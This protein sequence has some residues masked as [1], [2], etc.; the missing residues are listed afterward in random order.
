M[1]IIGE[2]IEEFVSKQID[3]RQKIY[4][5]INRTT[6]QL[7]Y[8][9]SRNAFIK[10]MSSVNIVDPEAF[11]RD[12]LTSDIYNVVSQYPGSQLAK[13]FMLF[14]GVTDVI[15]NIPKAGLAK[16]NSILND[17]SYGLGGLTFGY[18]PMPGITSIDIKSENRGSLKTAI[19]KIKA[20]NRTQFEIVDLLYLR[21]GFTVLLEWGNTIYFDN[22]GDFKSKNSPFSLQDVFFNTGAAPVRNLDYNEVL[23]QIRTLRRSSSGNYDALYGK[24]VNYEWN[25]A[26]DGSYDITLTVRSIGDVI[27]S[28][29]VN[30]LT[31]TKTNSS[32][33]ADEDKSY[34][35]SIQSYA[36]QHEI[37]RLFNQVLYL[38]AS[39]TDSNNVSISPQKDLSSQYNYEWLKNEYLKLFDYIFFNSHNLVP[40]ILLKF[41]GDSNRS[42][43]HFGT[44]LKFIEN[45]ILPKYYNNNSIPIIKFDAEPETNLVYYNSLQVSADPRICVINTKIPITSGN[46]YHYAMAASPYK[47]T[48][49]GVGKVMNIYFDFLYILTTMDANTDEEGNLSLIDF[50]KALCNDASKTLGGLNAFEPH[51]NEETNEIR[52]IDQTPLPNKNCVLTTLNRTKQN[53]AIIDLYGYY[54]RVNKGST[55]S[56]V[57]NFGIKTELNSSFSTII[58][59]GAQAQGQVVGE[60]AT[61]L[62]RM[63]RGLEDRIV[64]IKIDALESISPKNTQDP[65]PT[66]QEKFAEAWKNLNQFILSLG[67]EIGKDG[68][69]YNTYGGYEAPT[70]NETDANSYGTLF[71]NYLKYKEAIEAIKNNTSSGNIGFIPISLNLTLDGLSG[72]K[73]YNALKVDTSY[74]P[75]NYPETMDFIITGVSHKIQ[76]NLWVTDLTTVMVPKNIKD[77]SQEKAEYDAVEGPQNYVEVTSGNKTSSSARDA[78]RI[79]GID[80]A[81][82]INPN[83]I[84]FQS[85]S[86]STTAKSLASKYSNGELP[87]NILTTI[88]P[89]ANKRWYP[90]GQYRLAPAAAAAWFKWKAAMD[91]RKIPYSVSS[92]YRSKQHQASLGSGKGVAS[93]GSSPHGWGGALDFSNLYSL[94]GGSTNPTVNLNARIRNSVYEQMA[95]LGKQF[96]WYNPWRLSDQ[97][98]VDEIWHFEYWG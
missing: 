84:G 97:S 24:V 92:A 86:Y 66:P 58:T 60:D 15:T 51:I 46:S 20:W 18:R 90:D 5:S 43:I 16:D 27:E 74:L 40:F 32:G 21:L 89:G 9:N 17:A 96:G 77:N 57:R 35:K 14:N 52:I 37:G 23:S 31:T 94:V 61:A 19:I 88:G 55:A 39:L 78:T 95:E 75:S 69:A 41:K 1:N 28:L 6:E 85:Y 48:K 45:Y 98:G 34:D 63:N 3:V 76:N 71:R 53:T 22:E 13:K 70:L 10:L 7:Q 44:L 33:S 2:E 72:I 50:L 4:G 91:T 67:V 11:K 82:A 59:I 87:L 81:P 36:D 38:R 30:I 73:I 64:P 29:K 54:N 47:E 62:S 93:P 79:A 26:E 8:L 56:F 68:K 83:K 65:S 49:C 42:Y 80:P 12:D 25:F